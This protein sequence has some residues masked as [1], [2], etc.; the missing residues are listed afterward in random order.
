MLIN[1]TR[2]GELDVPDGK[3]VVMKRPILGFEGMNSFCLLER[4]EW[5]PFLWL[6]STEEPETAFIVVNPRVFFSGYH[7]EINPKEIAELEVDNLN[8]VETYVIVT[9]PEDPA[10][11][12][13]NLQGPVLINTANGYAKQL[14][15]VNSEYEVQHS[16][17]DVVPAD[18]EV[19]PRESELAPA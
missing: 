1:S 19:E 2:F 4:E 11:M 15:L 3:L 12:S 7:I 9:I 13:V 16:L 8:A 17:M 14:V 5:E 10:E 18:A 6:Q